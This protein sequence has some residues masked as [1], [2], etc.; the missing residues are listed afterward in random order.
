MWGE[1]KR[2]REKYKHTIINIRPPRNKTL[3]ITNAIK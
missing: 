1:A 3:I 2:Y